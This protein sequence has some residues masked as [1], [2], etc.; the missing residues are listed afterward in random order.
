MRRRSRRRTSSDSRNS[1]THIAQ[2]LKPSSRP[3][4]SVNSGNPSREASS[5]PNSALRTSL[6]GALP[7]SI[8]SIRSRPLCSASSK[9]TITWP[10]KTKV[11][12]PGRPD[13]GVARSGDEVVARLRVFVDG[14]QDDLQPRPVTRQ[15]REKHLGVG[16]MRAVAAHEHLERERGRCLRD[17][18]GHG[19]GAQQGR[20]APGE[21]AQ[22]TMPCAF[23]PRA[24][25][26]GGLNRQEPWPGHRRVMLVGDDDPALIHINHVPRIDAARRV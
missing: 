22:A 15:L 17:R 19:D 6:F 16:A 3:S 24:H 13:T 10:P 21:P 9:P 26:R 8:S 12:T 4:A 14:P 1:S 7:R 18:R 5:V 25:T 2:G 20:H 23:D 11:G